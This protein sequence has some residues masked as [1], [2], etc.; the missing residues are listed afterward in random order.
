MD[1]IPVI[2]VGGLVIYLY[3]KGLLVSNIIRCASRKNAG[4]MAF[5]LVVEFA[6]I[7]SIAYLQLEHGFARFPDP[8]IG[9]Q[10]VGLLFF[11]CGILLS[12]RARLELG[13]NYRPLLGTESPAHLVTSGPYR[14]LRHPIYSGMLFAAAGFELALWSPLL[15]FLLAGIILALIQ[16]RREEKLLAQA[17]SERWHCY[18][19]KTPYRL[20][21]GIF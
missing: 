21:R 1:T 5:Q 6:L 13:K 20:I 10:A 2:L 9:A 15:V 12:F 16:I 7:F 18:C 3:A 11:G 4:L 17:F 19:E 14:T 8:P